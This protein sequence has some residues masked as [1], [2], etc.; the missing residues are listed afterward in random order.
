MDKYSV[1]ILF[2][3][4]LQRYYTGSTNDI[5]RRF[6]EHNSGKSSATRGGRPWE[7]KYHEEFTN[8]SDAVQKEIQIKRR[9]AERFLID[10][11]LAG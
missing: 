6:M 10:K 11:D 8:R 2:S 1:Y 4:S 7:L 3:E 5:V 9:G